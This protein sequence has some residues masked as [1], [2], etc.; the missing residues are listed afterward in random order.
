VKEDFSSYLYH[1]VLNISV[2]ES[3]RIMDEFYATEFFKGI[4]PMTGSLLTT[5]SLKQKGYNLFLVTGRKYSLTQETNLWIEKYFPGIFSGI[6]FTNT[7]S[8]SGI[9]LKKSQVCKELN[10]K[11]IIEDDLMHITDCVSNDIQVMVYNH[12]WNQ[13]DLPKNITRV[14]SWNEIL[15]RIK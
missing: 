6:H 9:K 7:Y 11:I 4:T 8:G 12:P 13:R 14:S 10:A 3:R 15:E 2:E 1:E 5:F